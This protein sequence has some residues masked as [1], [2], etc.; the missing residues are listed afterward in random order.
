MGRSITKFG[1]IPLLTDD[2]TGGI[3]FTAVQEDL[4]TEVVAN[5][6]YVLLEAGNEGKQFITSRSYSAP[7]L[8]PGSGSQGAVLKGF[9]GSIEFTTH[10]G[11]SD[12]SVV[13]FAVENNGIGIPAAN[14]SDFKVL[15]DLRCDPSQEGSYREI[16]FD[17][18]SLFGDSV[19]LKRRI[20]FYFGIRLRDLKAEGR[21]KLKRIDLDISTGSA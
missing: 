14:P 19:E 11:L 15:A 21:V 12:F 6:L 16:D 4:R 9:K 3:G 7:S 18:F 1:S 20:S 2:P 8:T 5:G 17:L 10:G 13:V